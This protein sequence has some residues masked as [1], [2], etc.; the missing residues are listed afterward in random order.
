[1]SSLFFLL[2]AALGR[3]DQQLTNFI[4]ADSNKKNASSKNSNQTKSESMCLNERTFAFAGAMLCVV[5]GLFLSWQAWQVSAEKSAKLRAEQ[6]RTEQAT[7]L[8]RFLLDIQ[9]KIQQGLN[10]SSVTDALTT[11]PTEGVDAHAAA[12]SALKIQLPDMVA[13]E[14]FSADVSEVLDPATKISNTLGAILLQAH[15]EKKPAPIQS[16]VEGKNPR[17]LLF[18]LPVNRGETRV[19]YA[20][21]QMP[22]TLLQST[23]RSLSL[24]DVHLDLRETNGRSSQIIE[25]IGSAASLQNSYDEGVPVPGSLFRVTTSIPEFF[26]LVPKNGITLGI[27]IF[28]VF[29]TGAL[30]F[31]IRQVGLKKALAIVGRK[32]STEEETRFDQ[33]MD[34]AAVPRAVDTATPHREAETTVIS[35]AATLA[36]VPSVSVDRSIFRAYDI[37][38]VLDKTLNAGVA[39]LIGQ[40]IGS[41]AQQ[42]GLREIVVGRDG[43]LSGPELSA[44]LIEGLRVTGCDVIDIGAVPTPVVYFGA[45]FLN[46]G[47]GVMVTGSHNPP[48]YNGFKIVLG[49]ETLSED[50]IQ[51]LYARI[52]ESRFAKGNGGLQ[53]MD[54]KRDY[55]ERITSDIQIEK[56]LKVVVDCGNGI[57]GII[58]PNLLE[59]IGCEVIPLYCDVDGTFPNHHPDPSDPHNLR[60]LIASVKQS[61]ADLGVAFDGDGDRLGVVTKRGEIIYPDRLLMLFAIDVLT[62]NPGATIIYDVKCTGH[63]QSMILKHSGSPL[64]WKTGHSLIKSKMREVDAQLAGEMSGHFF[65]R[66]RWYGFDDGL[67]S[68]ARLLEILASNLEKRGPQEIFDSLPKGVSTPELKIPMN[69]GEHYQFMEDFKKKTRFEG[70]H[71]TSIDGVRADYPDGWGLVRCSNTTPCLVLRFDADNDTV[72]MRIQEVFR[73][74]LLSVN[75]TLK[76]PF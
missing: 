74:Q 20:A 75:Q 35:K 73:Q 64:M 41:E 24:N 8:S 66:E 6:T 28:L 39:R 9:K 49:G 18:V 4:M 65:F 55:I 47:S 33:W 29:T 54:I 42:R 37:R 27:L 5:A 11:A 34:N 43:R 38:G 17:Y 15:T 50:A 70:A 40:A 59:G 46:I 61:N 21:I 14:F 3:S 23:L 16:R 36:E 30:L 69:E 10:H 13:V 19:A 60:D 67:Y 68:A 2:K 62:R 76:L 56:K 12:G 31:W 48:E 44:A 63:L 72:L 58:A 22:Y 51:N 53:V 7:A 26:I 71:I 45:Y 25:S 57:P 1:V 52:S 32:T